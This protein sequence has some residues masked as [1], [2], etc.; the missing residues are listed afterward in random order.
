MIKK[1]WSVYV[2][3]NMWMYGYLPVEVSDGQ[4][5]LLAAR[6]DILSRNAHISHLLL[7]RLTAQVFPVHRVQM[8]GIFILA[9]EIITQ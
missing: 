3:V 9:T 8:E 4:V 1:R 6:D 7:Q 2:T 5:S